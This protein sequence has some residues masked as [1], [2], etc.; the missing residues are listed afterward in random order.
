MRRKLLLIQA[1]LVL[2]VLVVFVLLAKQPPIL[3]SQVP[4]QK[5]DETLN[6]KRASLVQDQ[7]DHLEKEV[8]QQSFFYKQVLQKLRHIADDQRSQEQMTIAVLLIACNRES[9]V[10][11]SLDLLLRYRPS[12]IQFPITVSQD[13]GHQPTKMAILSYG[14]Q[15]SLIEQP[16]LSVIE[17]P[18]KEKKF[19]GYFYIARHYKWALDY[20]FLEAGHDAVVIVE[21]DLDVSPD[22]FEY[23]SATYPLLRADPSLWCVSAWND[24]G[25]G[26]LVDVTNGA[27]TLYRTDFFPG[28]GWMLTKDVWEELSPKWPKSY[29]DDWMRAPEQRRDRACIRPEISRTRTFGKK[30]VSNGL[31]FEKH[32]KYIHLNEK[33][34]QFSSMNLTYLL[35]P[36]YDE[37][38][39][40]RVQAAEV[41]SLSQAKSGHLPEGGEYRL[42]YH[43]KDVFKKTTKALGL[44]DD[45]KAGVPR[46]GYR[47]VISFMLHNRR[48]FLAPNNNWKGYDPTWS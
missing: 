31:F 48:I 22:F 4:G 2:W 35:K 12:Q 30:G 15:V 45:F 9:A 23:F 17:V 11:R 18:P 46:T 29:W 5:G 21:D 42:L 26:N 43:T 39:E 8:S 37:S 25:K 27:E 36:S 16:D 20:M 44:M 6:P 24:N 33:R 47:G 1:L 28:L 40:R 19:K 32:L 10:R 34:V 7:L 13:C 38:F 41:V 14:D 3:G